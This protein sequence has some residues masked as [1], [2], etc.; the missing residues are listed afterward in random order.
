MISLLGK[1]ANVAI[2][3]HTNVY[4]RQM[5]LILLMLFLLA[6][7]LKLQY[8]T[9]QRELHHLFHFKPL[10]LRFVTI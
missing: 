3:C 4:L 1:D 8:M 2:Y 10:L 9:R 6:V 7:Y 5:M